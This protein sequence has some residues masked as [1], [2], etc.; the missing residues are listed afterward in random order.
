MWLVYDWSTG[1]LIGQYPTLTVAFAKARE[2]SLNMGGGI[3]T[4]VYGP[5][6]SLVA[7]FEYGRKV[8]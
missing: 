3:S 4:A 5:S 8:R 1:E 7:R 6:G 2:Y